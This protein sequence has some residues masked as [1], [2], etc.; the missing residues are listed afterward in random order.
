MPLA[1]GL[2]RP[3][4]GQ[5]VKKI[6]LALMVLSAFVNAAS[7]GPTA[8]K[9]K[10]E[11]VEESLARGAE[12]VKD[13]GKTYKISFDWAV[14]DGIDWSKQKRSK[15]DAVGYEIEN[16]RWVGFDVNKLCQDKDYKAAMQKFD[17]VVYRVTTE[18]AAG[19]LRPTATVDGKTLVFLNVIG[20]N[21]RSG[22]DFAAAAKKVL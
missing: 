15:D 10:R 17:S 2:S 6:V 5:S 19:N 20:S 14:F 13:C 16:V 21:T 3:E 18:Q 8:D 22:G 12:D 9:K 1:T 4:K 7:A 11:A